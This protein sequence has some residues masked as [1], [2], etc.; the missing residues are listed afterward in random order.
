[1][2]IIYRTHRPERHLDSVFIVPKTRTYGYNFNND[3][4]WYIVE[5]E[6]KVVRSIFERCIAGVSAIQISRDLTLEGIPT[7]KN[8]ASWHNKTIHGILNNSTYTGDLLYQKRFTQ[9]TL[10]NRI[11][12]NMGESSQVLIEDHHPAI[13]VRNTWD[14]ARIVLEKRRQ[15]KNNKTRSMPHDKKEFFSRFKCSECGCFYFHETLRNKIETRHRWKCKAA[16]R[17]HPLIS[18]D[19]VHIEEED[20]MRLFMTMLLEIK[21]DKSFEELL[22]KNIENK[23]LTL[24]EKQQLAY[25]ENENQ[26]EYL[27]LY[28][29]VEEGGKS[30]EDTIEIKRHTDSIMA[31]Q[32]QINEILDKGD[33]YDFL[34]REKNWLL[35]ELDNLDNK[36]SILYRGDIFKR[37]IKDGIVHPNNVIT[38]NLTFGISR[39]VG[40]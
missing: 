35:K 24:Q 26:K 9:D 2:S 20:I 13:I 27:E 29:L 39:T 32:D 25:L 16:L 34:I 10:T 15:K 40:K 19:T 17:K 7:M 31:I 12:Q 4:T 28:R 5:E 14:R 33:A 6:A 22:S 18:C 1:M 21:R 30:G 23:K 8:K 38:F 11:K 37:I 36:K 3:R